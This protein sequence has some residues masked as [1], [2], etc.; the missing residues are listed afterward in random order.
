ML[1]FFL[2]TPKKVVQNFF[3][4]FPPVSEVLLDP[5]GTTSPLKHIR[6]R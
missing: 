5:L 4:K 2:K 6:L 3:Q 1:I